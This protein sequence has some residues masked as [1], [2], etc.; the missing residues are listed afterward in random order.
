M[1]RKLLFKNWSIAQPFGQL[2]AFLD[3][4]QYQDFSWSHHGYNVLVSPIKD[5]IVFLRD[6]CETRQ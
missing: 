6:I 1:Y 4:H 2:S 3:A 5:P